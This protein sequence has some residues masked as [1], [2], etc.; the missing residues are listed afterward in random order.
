MRIYHYPEFGYLVGNWPKQDRRKI[1]IS[2][3]RAET[4]RQRITG[5]QEVES[6]KNQLRPKGL[7]KSQRCGKVRDKNLKNLIKI[8]RFYWLREII[9]GS[10]KKRGAKLTTVPLGHIPEYFLG[11]GFLALPTHTIVLLMQMSM[12]YNQWMLVRKTLKAHTKVLYP[13]SDYIH[14]LYP[15][16]SKVGFLLP[17]STPISTPLLNEVQKNQWINRSLLANSSSHVPS[18]TIYYFSQPSCRQY[19][20][21]PANEM[22]LGNDVPLLPVLPI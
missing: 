6:K 8:G 12:F 15:V 21:V 20:G 1:Y 5:C 3:A 10:W 11:E 13:A 18:I 9:K 2:T 22:G 17:L 19:D 14:Q 7:S 16:K 4:I